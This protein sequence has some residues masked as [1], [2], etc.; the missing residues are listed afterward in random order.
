MEVEEVRTGYVDDQNLRHVDVWFPGVEE[1]TTVAVVDLD[2][3]KAIFFKNE[4]RMNDK[5]LTALE[6]ITEENFKLK[7]NETGL[8]DNIAIVWTLEDVFE[9]A[10]ENDQ[11]LTSDDARRVLQLVD[12]NFDANNGINWDNIDFWISRYLRELKN[13]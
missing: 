10:A 5:V 6:Q 2:T 1:G 12:R 3:N 13:G 8:P 7:A 9:R 11:E 4:F